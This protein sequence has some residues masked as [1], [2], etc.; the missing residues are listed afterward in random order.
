M[1]LPSTNKYALTKAL[2]EQHS[3]NVKRAFT[4]VWW[5]LETGTPPSRTVS[6]VKRFLD[7]RKDD[8]V[9]TDEHV[10]ALKENFERLK[11]KGYASEWVP[12]SEE[13]DSDL[14][15]VS[16]TEPSKKVTPPDLRLYRN[17]GTGK[18]RGMS[19]SEV[20]LHEIN[21]GESWKLMGKDK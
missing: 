7:R 21:H 13:K 3:F 14:S 10:K 4:L 6:T 11:K 2:V 17:L 16:I 18:L 9:L 19:I 15:N 8:F 5:Y 20:V 1:K 12:R